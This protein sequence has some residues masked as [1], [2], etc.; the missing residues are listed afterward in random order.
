[1]LVQPRE[2][3]PNQ[4]WKKTYSIEIIFE[5]CGGRK[6]N[7]RQAVLEEMMPV[8]STTKAPKDPRGRWDTDQFGK[9]LCSLFIRSSPLNVDFNMLHDDVGISPAPAPARFKSV[10]DLGNPDGGVASFP[11]L[12]TEEYLRVGFL[13]CDVVIFD[14]EGIAFGGIGE[15]IEVAALFLA[16]AHH[17]VLGRQARDCR[18][19]N[20]A[21]S[22]RH[23][24]G[25]VVFLK[26]KEEGG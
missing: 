3:L 17:H 6:R 9:G 15:G 1:M 18:V 7:R 12:P 14:K 11:T 10:V 16:E 5:L 21:L 23:N 13:H 25:T 22:S 2:L 26:I 20:F 19:E 4:T 24:N 8:G